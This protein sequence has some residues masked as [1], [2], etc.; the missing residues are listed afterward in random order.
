M[1]SDN[2]FPINLDSIA[3]LITGF[4]LLSITLVIWFG[5]QIG[6]RVTADLSTD[7]PIG[8]YEALTF[9]FSEPVNRFLVI[10]IFNINPEVAGSFNWVDTKT[11]QFI[12]YEPFQLDTIYTVTLEAG[13]WTQNGRGTKKPVSWNFHVRQPLVVYLATEEGKSPLWAIDPESGDRTPLV[14]EALK[15]FNFDTSYNGE[16]VVFSAFNEQGGID[17]WRVERGGGESTL[18]LQCGPDRCSVPAISFYGSRVAYVREAAI[19]GPVLQHGAP[20][21]WILDL[22]TRQNSPLYEDQQIIGYGPVWSP[23]GTRLSSYDGLADEI[24]L[25]DILTGNQLIVPSQTGGPVT[26]SGDS[27]TLVFTDVTSNETGTYTRVR[28]AK[29]ITDEIITLLGDSDDIDYHYNAVAWSPIENKLV[30]GLQ[31]EQ[32]DPSKAL[33]LIDIATLGGQVI[34]NQPDYVYNEPQWDPWG[35]ALVFQ[36]FKLKGAYTPEIGLWMPGYDEPQFITEGILPHW[37]P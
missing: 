8:P 26:W 27:N 24:R 34:A 28:Q 1:K 35:R 19:P 29:L 13:A 36:Q 33:W 2:K 20:R 18:M 21:I 4:L 16:F 31:F 15:V 14:D 7:N 11:L 37:L 10:D 3:G 6:I 25:L 5:S 30:I 9:Q 22:D 17:L 12:P 23:D 32:D